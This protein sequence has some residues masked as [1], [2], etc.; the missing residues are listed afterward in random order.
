MLDN[1]SRG[2]QANVRVM[3]QIRSYIIQLLTPTLNISIYGNLVVTQRVERAQNVLLEV[4]LILPLY[5]SANYSLSV[6]SC[7]YFHKKTLI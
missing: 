6:V 1:M 2:F 7:R 3:Y 4:A 5:G